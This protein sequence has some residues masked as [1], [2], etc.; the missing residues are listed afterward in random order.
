M[1]R[2]QKKS[3]S[4]KRRSME[5]ARRETQNIDE[6][7]SKRN[8]VARWIELEEKLEEENLRE[9]ESPV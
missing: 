7:S 3:R 5:G 9:R 6:W 2:A 8:A 1:E 4:L